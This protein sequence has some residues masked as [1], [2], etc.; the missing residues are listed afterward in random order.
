MRQWGSKDAIRPILRSPFYLI[1]R[2]KM[3]LRLLKKEEIIRRLEFSCKHGHNGFEHPRC[4]ARIA[5]RPERI[6]F[7]DIETTN[8][9]APYGY[10]ISY[11]ILS[12]DGVLVKRAITSVEIKNGIYDKHLCRQFIKD[13]EQFDRFVGHY[14]VRFDFPF[15]RSRCVK[16]GLGFPEYTSK[17]HID[18]WFILRSKFKLHSNRLEA[19]CDFFGIE[20]KKHRI[21][22]DIWNAAQTGKKSAIEYVLQHNIEDVVS[23]S[24]VWEK[25]HRYIAYN[26][27]RSI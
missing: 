20:S 2:R 7:F 4:W 9:N 18:T 17:Y 10:I 19:A 5:D 25:I 24:K 27:K 22:S 15:I 3:N 14:S 16:H 11:C 13:C 21:N 1:K 8:L 23:L 6:G 26:S 12:N